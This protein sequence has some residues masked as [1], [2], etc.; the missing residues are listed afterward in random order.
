MKLSAFALASCSHIDSSAAALLNVPGRRNFRVGCVAV[1][2]SDGWDSCCQEDLQRPRDGRKKP[3][4]KQRIPEQR[5]R[6]PGGEGDQRRVVRIAESRMLAASDV[7]QFVA[8]VTVVAVER[9]V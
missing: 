9:K 1:I 5:A 8:E 4:S 3:Q 6:K 7:V 2:Q